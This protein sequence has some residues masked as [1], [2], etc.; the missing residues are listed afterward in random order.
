MTNTLIQSYLGYGLASARPTTPSTDTNAAPFY[1]ATDT[2]VLSQYIPGTGWVTV[3]GGYS[4]GTTPTVVQSGNNVTGN[5]SIT[6]GAAPTNGN[7]LVA[8]SF[9]TPPP[10]PGT[11]W[12]QLAQNTTGTDYGTI[13]YKVAGAAE[14]AT[15][16]PL[17]ANETPGC[18][19]IWEVNG[20]NA[21]WF[22]GDI[23]EA[24]QNGSYAFSPSGGPLDSGLLF[25]GAIGLVSSSGNFVNGYGVVQDQFVK[26]G[27]SRQI[28]AGHSTLGKYPIG[29]IAA[30]ISAASNYKALGLFITH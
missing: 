10:S 22:A 13:F 30:T 5:A 25:L 15:Q 6:L 26:T 23:L 21:T 29:Q 11:G 16:S 19:V 1:Y 4:A 9:N 20:Q 17:S 12:T 2:Q 3:G 18:M 28:F 7:L 14:S 24:E 27:S 8:M